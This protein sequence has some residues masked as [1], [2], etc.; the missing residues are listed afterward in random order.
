MLKK[1]K[2]SVNYLDQIPRISVPKW[3][4][5]EDGLVEVTVENKGFFNVIAQKCFHRPRTSYIKLDEY[6]SCVFQQI[7]GEKSIYEI[8]QKV[9]EH[10]GKEAEPLYERLTTFFRILAENKYI[11]YKK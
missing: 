8:G 11:T 9:K 1:K 3:E 2:E 10:F 5:L 6:G 4:V 7:D